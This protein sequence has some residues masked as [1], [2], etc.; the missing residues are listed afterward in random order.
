MKPR[1]DERVSYSRPYS[2]RSTATAS[3]LGCS[4]T[5]HSGAACTELIEGGEPGD[6]VCRVS[7]VTSRASVS[8]LHDTYTTREAR[9]EAAACLG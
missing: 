7:R 9:R 4:T 2:G 8:G 3:D 5:P 6:A 1:P